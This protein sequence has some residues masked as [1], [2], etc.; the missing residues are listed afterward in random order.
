[1]TVVNEWGVCPEVFIHSL[2]RHR[3]SITLLTYLQDGE[4]ELH[5]CELDGHI[6][7]SPSSAC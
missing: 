2:F 3:Q 4:T 1:M 6:N 7:Y 5:A